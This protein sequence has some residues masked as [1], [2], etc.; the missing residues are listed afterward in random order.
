MERDNYWTRRITR[1][2][3]LGGVALTGVGVAALALTG[4]GDDDSSGTTSTAKPSV[5]AG[6]TGTPVQG[7]AV[8]ESK[9]DKT[10][11]LH[12]R[13]GAPMA[14]INPYKGLDSGLLWGFTIL[15]PLFYTPADTGIR[16][17]FLAAKIEQP[18]PQ[19][20]TITLKDAVFHNVA[21]VNGRAVKAGDVKASWEAYA[22]SKTSS[23]SAWWGS[24]LDTI[25]VIDD[26]TLNVKQ[27]NVDA[28]T[29]SSTNAGSP[30]G[31]ILPAEMV[32][33]PDTMDTNL[34][35]SG[36]FQF[37]SAQNGSNP[38]IKR[39]DN[40]RIKGEPW[41]AGIE[42]KL[43]Q[44]QAQALASFLSKDID[45]VAPNNKLERDD[46]V[47]KAGKD[48]V[49]V[50]SQITG[51]NWILQTRADG[52]FKDLR[53]NRAISEALDR[54]EF[55][56][57]MN[58]GDGVKSAPVPA[59]F[60]A[61]AMSDADLAATYGKFDV[62]DAKA[63]LTATG[64]D[65]TKEY[66]LKYIT[67]GDRYAQ[68][69]QVIQS[70]LAKNLGIKIKLIG[71]DFGKWLTQS[72]YG[73]DYDAFITFPNLD[74][75]DPSSYLAWY[76]KTSGGRQNSARFFDDELDAAV[77]AQ[78]AILDDKLRAQAVIDIQKKAWDKN[79]PTIPVFTAITSNVTWNY[80]K[81]RT[82]NRGSYGLFSGR[83][84]IDKS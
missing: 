49:A 33:S 53:I 21:P 77:T 58:F 8:D 17:N 7:G 43:I 80:V 31:G 6:A 51:S 63:L 10:G 47:S 75:D 15:D 19:Q 70:Q 39:F 68:F 50:E 4:C 29:F 69:G 60:P 20:F 5:A 55:I 26:K 44:E 11:V 16:E 67:P 25:T 34:I 79:A 3:V 42:Y 48:S 52:P 84:Y 71:E 18:D 64:F 30:I 61:H 46:T 74:Y 83:T 62:A 41:L 22:T 54:N 81:G 27:K 40:W 45:A 65:T 12:A 35:G 14:S 1:R 24:T 59:K 56:Q 66:G 38:K 82:L 9:V 73:S 37:V 57:L 28:W 78:K 2:R 13:Q 76:L 36:R 72:L 32:A 23:K